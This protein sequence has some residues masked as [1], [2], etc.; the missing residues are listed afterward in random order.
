VDVRDVGVIERGEDLCFTPE[1]GEVVRIGGEGFWQDLERDIPIQLRVA[2]AIHLTHPA[3]TDGSENL[4]GT[5][6]STGCQRHASRLIVAMKQLAAKERSAFCWRRR[7]A[8]VVVP[9]FSWRVYN[10]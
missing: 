9:R 5:N 6:V 1:A 4:V 8:V 3:R 2:R 7:G 10:L